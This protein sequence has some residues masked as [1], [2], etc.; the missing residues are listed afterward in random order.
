MNNVSIF[1]LKNIHWRDVVKSIWKTEKDTFE[2]Y[3]TIQPVSNNPD[4]KHYLVISLSEKTNKLFQNFRAHKVE[5][6]DLRARIPAYSDP[7][8]GN[9]DHLNLLQ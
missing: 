4:L 6:A 8:F 3:I 2:D 7:V 9:K 1:Y 5:N